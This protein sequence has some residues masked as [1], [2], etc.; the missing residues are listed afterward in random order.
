M[1]SLVVRSERVVLPDGTRPATIHIS[2]GRITHV[3]PHA[4]SASREAVLDA[5]MAVVMPGLVDTHVHVNEPGRTDWEGFE[6]ATRAAAAGGVTTLV[7]MPL[8]SVPATTTTR[9]LD[10]KRHSAE[11]KCHVDVAFWG[12]IVPGNREDLAPLAKAGVLGFK[13]FLSPS[14]VDEFEHVT[15]GDLRQA[16]PVLAVLRLPLLVHAEVPALLLQPVGDPCSYETWLRSR[17]STA[18]VAAIELLGRLAREYGAHL[19]VVHLATKDAVPVIRQLRRDGVQLTVETCPHY[20][21]FAAEEIQHGAT[22]LK[23]APPIRTASNREA[24][25]QGLRAG[26]IDLIA[27]DH[28]PAP[29]ALKSIEAGDFIAAWGGIASLQLGLS[30]I[31]TQASARGLSLDDV[32]RWMSAAPAQLAGL[33]SKGRIAAGADAD[34][35]FFDPDESWIVDPAALHHRHPVTPYAGKRLRGSVQRTIVR[36]ET[37]FNDGRVASAFHGRMI[38]SRA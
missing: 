13:C 3:G 26:D 8:N 22:A 23:C 30:A 24:L 36:G 20:L 27:S 2:D 21:T 1:G 38:A 10:A 19:H 15:E 32:V 33:R 11:G 6:H 29:A 7:D 31:W 12:G 16:L 9:A 4:N 5:R 17:P 28:S 34:L 37:V 25:W 14:G 18:E 35:V